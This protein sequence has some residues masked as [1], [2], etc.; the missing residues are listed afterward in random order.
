MNLILEIDE[1]LLLYRDKSF[2]SIE[3][4]LRSPIKRELYVS[5][6]PIQA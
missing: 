5:K 2:N 4:R 3:E 6:R 1:A